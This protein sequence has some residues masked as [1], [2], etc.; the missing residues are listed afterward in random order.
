MTELRRIRELERAARPLDPGPGE[1]RRLRNAVV[2][3]SERFLRTIDTLKGFEEADDQGIGLLGSPISE[4]GI[5]LDAVDRAAGARRG[6]PRRQPGL[7]RAPGLHPGRRDLPLGAGR[8]S[9]RGQ[10]QVRGHLL[11]RPRAGADGE[12]AAA[13]GGRPGGLPGRG[14]RQHRLRRQHRQPDGDRHGP[15]RPW[16]PRGRSRLGGG[17][18]HDPGPPL[19]R[20][21]PPHRGAR[22][23]AGSL[24]PD[25]RRLPDAARG[26]G[27]G[28]RRRPCPGREAMAD[29]RRRGHHGHRRGGPARRDR[30]HRASASAAG[31]TW[32]RRTAASSS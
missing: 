17:L 5:P 7:G 11:Y 31:S 26:A 1:R 19:P 12:H 29:H 23:G 16:P 15:R 22:R 18:P 14:R 13:L 10:Q 8:L 3:S 2:A 21:G 4:Q 30:H 24:R 27:G 32:T 20:E 25:R 9:G 28:H 6:P